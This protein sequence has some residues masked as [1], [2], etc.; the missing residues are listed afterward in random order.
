MPRKTDPK[1]PPQLAPPKTEAERNA[2]LGDLWALTAMAF[3]NALRSG[4]AS[5]AT[6]NAARAWLADNGVS[7]ESLRRLGGGALDPAL[8][9]SLPQFKDDTEDPSA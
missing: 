4:D 8:L 3:T 2:L 1:E 5:A 7:A 6:L 9:E